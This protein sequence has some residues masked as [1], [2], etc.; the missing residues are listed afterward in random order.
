MLFPKAAK[1]N[2]KITVKNIKK[3]DMSQHLKTAKHEKIYH[4]LK[5]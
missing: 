5:I 2:S 1:N 4:E 3:G